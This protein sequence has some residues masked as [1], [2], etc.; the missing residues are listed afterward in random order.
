MSHIQY[1]QRV[2]S[3]YFVLLCRISFTVQQHFKTILGTSLHNSKEIFLWL[4]FNLDGRLFYSS[5]TVFKKIY[6][7][8]SQEEWTQPIVIII[9]AIIISIVPKNTATNLRQTEINDA[10]TSKDLKKKSF[11]ILF[12][13]P[14]LYCSNPTSQIFVFSF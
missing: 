3:S 6:R 13:R 8:L 12:V 1:W 2:F 5:K 10:K 9:S 4:N 14:Y 11:L 7:Q